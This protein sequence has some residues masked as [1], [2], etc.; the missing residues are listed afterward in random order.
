MGGE[1]REEET[2]VNYIY[3]KM[4]KSSRAAAISGEE[5]MMSIVVLDGFKVSNFEA[6]I[7]APF[8]CFGGES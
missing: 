7:R 5:A 3:H 2:K 1:G 8:N 6:A 4:E